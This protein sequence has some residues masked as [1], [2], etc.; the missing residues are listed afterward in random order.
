MTLVYKSGS[1][2]LVIAL[3]AGLVLAGCSNPQPG[4]DKTLAGAVLGAGWGAG[5]GAIIG[6][7]V[8]SGD[9]GPGAAI[10]AGFG[11]VA[12]ATSGYA[13]DQTED[14][15]VQLNK[16]LASLKIANLTNRNQLEHL[17]S[18]LDQAAVT[19]AL[20]GGVYQVYFDEDETSLKAGAIAALETI[21]ESFKAS[22]HA[23]HINVDGH[24]DDTGTPDYNQR[25]AEAR[26]R[27]VSAYLAARGIS[28]DQITVASYGST[29]PVASNSTPTGRQ[30]NR[31]VEVYI[32][33]SAGTGTNQGN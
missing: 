21:G 14:T 9:V 22:P 30:L 4:P 16:E 12:G 24:T 29:R 15:Q 28:V 27:T 19:R 23:Y 26:A 1:W 33:Q 3:G 10:G 17:Q 25:V 11:A 31:R 7:Q 20:P 13:Y 8:T 2:G 32:A 18:K 5:T 6:H